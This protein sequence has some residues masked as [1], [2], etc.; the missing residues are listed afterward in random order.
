M[1]ASIVPTRSSETNPASSSKPEIKTSSQ[2]S[3]L[4]RLLNPSVVELVALHAAMTPDAPAIV[5]CGKVMT[6]GE[7]DKRANRLANCLVARG[8]GMDAI[9]GLCLE[10]SP[11][12]VMCALAILKAGGGFLPLDPAYPTDR[13]LFMLNDAQPRVLITREALAQKFPSAPWS[14]LAIDDDQNVR[15]HFA[16]VIPATRIG[17]DQLA[18]VIYTSGSTGQPKGVQITHD[19]LLN[20]VLW[21]RTAFG[22]TSSDRASHLASVG[23]DA[24]IWEGWP[25]LTAGASLHLPDEETR[26]SPEC[27]RHWLVAEELTIRFLP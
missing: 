22:V 24:A 13:L 19:S 26:V 1:S 16:D 4:T 12:S 9:V 15:N 27:L 3:V 5:G 23:F 6:Y 20:L 7:L 25:Y 11:E 17:R 18:Y 2:V 8:V 14:V 10:R 21:H